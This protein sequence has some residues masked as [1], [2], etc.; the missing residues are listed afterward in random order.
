MLLLTLAWLSIG[1]AGCRRSATTLIV[2]V[3]SDFAE[4]E[5]SSVRAT[6]AWRGVAD[7]AIGAMDGGAPEFLLTG[8]R[9][10]ILRRF[11]GSIVVAPAVVRDGVP[12]DVTLRVTPRGAP[13]SAFDVAARVRF[14]R[15]RTS[16]LELFVPS[17][18]GDSA[19]RDR[20]IRRSIDE[21]IEYTCAGE[22]DD[23]CVPLVEQT[24]QE[25]RADSSAPPVDV[26]PPREASTDAGFDGGFDAEADASPEA[27]T[28][29]G[30]DASDAR[31]GDG[32]VT[33]TP[34]ALYPPLNAVFAGR[35]N[36][37]VFRANS[38][39][40]D[41]TDIVLQF[42]R[43]PVD[44]GSP[45]PMG[46]LTGVTEQRFAI[47]AGSCPRVF[48]QAI[49]L[50]ALGPPGPYAWRVGY[51]RGMDRGMVSSGWRRFFTRSNNSPSSIV[52]TLP[53]FDGDGL[54]DVIVG[55]PGG[56]TP[57]VALARSRDL[58]RGLNSSMAFPAPEAMAAGAPVPSPS[59]GGIDPASMQMVPGYGATL[60]LLGDGSI[61]GS[62]D[63]LVAD[64]A[65]NTFNGHV[66]RFYWAA[67][68]LVRFDSSDAIRGSG[69][70][71]G[72]TMAAADFNRD[73]YTDLLVGARA[74]DGGAGRVWLYRGGPN[75]FAFEGA[76]TAFTAPMGASGFGS[77]I[78]AGCD[79]DND[80]FADA[81]VGAPNN[82]GLVSVLFGRADAMVPLAQGPV[83]VPSSGGPLAGGFGSA[84][85][86][87]GDLNGNGIADLVV[88]AGR[89]TAR[90]TVAAFLGGPSW[91]VAAPTSAAGTVV[92]TADGDRLG[93]ALAFVGAHGGIADTI[94]I[95]EAESPAPGFSGIVKFMDSPALTLAG[96]V[97]PAPMVAGSRFGS[98][99][100]SLGDYDGDGRAEFASSAPGE[101]ANEGAVFVFT[102]PS[103]M[104]TPTPRE[105][106]VLRPSAAGAGQLYGFALAR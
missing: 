97:T 29:A 43:R 69:G 105:L 102:R 84:L 103:V 22:G 17:L 52:G 68:D 12:V 98:A 86:C 61:D 83:L 91:R 30:T 51:A 78:A 63:I 18:C 4:G 74:A 6:V 33:G 47:P 95:G 90:A 20:C 31:V 54:G 67:G 60:T 93:S 66:H 28:D 57:S 96:I 56:P 38:D 48:T 36:T 79:L 62:Q 5:V 94:A 39:C 75:G 88:T 65:A 42:C 46:E 9:G 24:A 99:I 14:A 53:D 11:P 70:G 35:P 21:G 106:A 1:A 45:C 10:E 50:S 89:P 37:F 76:P 40:A 7:G 41:A 55:S 77:A 44:N 72:R 73:G 49:D 23:P 85:A 19:V 15:E 104:G 71:F 87:D 58:S 25:Y 80:G 32:A 13:S 101:N 92:A 59:T 100:V 8:E 64:P 3:R 34:S 26:R 16:V 27:G 81:I 2:R 82:D